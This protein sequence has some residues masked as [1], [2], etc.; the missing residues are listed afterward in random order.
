MIKVCSVFT[1]KNSKFAPFFCQKTL[2]KK[3]QN[4]SF[5]RSDQPPGQSNRPALFLSP[6]PHAAFPE[7][8]AGLTGLGPV[9]PD[10]PAVFRRRTR[11]LRQRLPFSLARKE[12]PILAAA[13]PFACVCACAAVAQSLAARFGR[14]LFF[15]PRACFRSSFFLGSAQHR[16]A[17]RSWKIGP[18]LHHLILI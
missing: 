12:L 16:S 17:D 2:K 4:N 1:Q 13:A 3:R 9:I 5:G 14:T 11:I 18:C 7:S 6:S 10:R 15:F 8:W